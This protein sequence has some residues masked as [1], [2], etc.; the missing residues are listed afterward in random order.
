MWAHEASIE[1]TA[2]P[3]AIWA[4]FVDVNGWKRWNAGIERIEIHG[5]FASGTRFT[6]QPPGAEA[7]T[8]LLVDVRENEGF[9]DETVIDA[10]RVLV[11]H[12]IEPLD[13]GRTRIVY[14]TEI[15]GPG[16]AEFGPAI[17]ADFPEVLLA[18]S[19]LA[20][21]PAAV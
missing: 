12:R 7:F 13:S 9:T 1:T 4:L 2:A 3:A 10:T 17:T 19:R 18:L 21:G 8:S 20:E 14:G 15:T 16:A 5:P 6:M 11:H